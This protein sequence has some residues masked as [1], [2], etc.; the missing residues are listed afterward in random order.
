MERGARKRMK[1]KQVPVRSVFYFYVS[2]I[3]SND[4]RIM[5]FK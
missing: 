3:H 5:L 2:A 1:G 4:H